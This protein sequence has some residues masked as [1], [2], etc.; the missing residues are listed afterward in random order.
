MNTINDQTNKQTN[1]QEKSF[2]STFLLF[3]LHS[4]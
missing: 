4:Y 3:E 2:S 1:K